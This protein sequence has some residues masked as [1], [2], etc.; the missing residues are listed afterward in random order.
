MKRLHDTPTLAA[1]E[2][3]WDKIAIIRD[4]QIRSH[5]DLSF[6][7]VLTPCLKRLISKGDWA[8][9]VDFGCGSGA[10]TEQMSKN[11]QSIVGLDVSGV[12]IEIARA[13]KGNQDNIEYLHCSIEE[14]P[15]LYPNRQHTMGISNMVLMDSVDLRKTLHSMRRSLKKGALLVS[16]ITHPCFW[17]RYW[18]YED[19]EW[20][21]YTKEQA[22][23]AE[24]RI[25]SS[26]APIG[27]TI[28]F[29]R[30]LE[31][32]FDELRRQGFITEAI[33]EPLPPSNL[34]QEYLSKWKFPRFLAILCRAT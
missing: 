28:H 11:S 31:S 5:I 7:H 6:W 14:Y 18:G 32:Y 13:N 34:P 8:S 24:F 15:R 16:T 26:A 9:V 12:S 29:H 17:P 4:I 22:I 23:L 19:A 33:E 2:A 21:S 1:I 10:L 3:A 27:E 20:F 25:S 30:P